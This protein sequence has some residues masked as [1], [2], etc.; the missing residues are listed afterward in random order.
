MNT[1]N[2][3]HLDINCNGK[4]AFFCTYIYIPGKC[5]ACNHN[6]CIYIFFS[7]R[8]YQYVMRSMK[9]TYDIFQKSNDKLLIRK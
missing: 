1:I 5:I 4:I 8:M 9:D 7:I 3:S 2:E 6:L